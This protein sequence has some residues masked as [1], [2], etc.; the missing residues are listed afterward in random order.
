M[1]PRVDLAVTRRLQGADCG[2]AEW[3]TTET[4]LWHQLVSE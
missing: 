2:K 4:R 3:Q 1:D